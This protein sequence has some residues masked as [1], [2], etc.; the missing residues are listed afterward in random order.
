MEM[1]PLLA[2]FGLF[3][4]GMKQLEEAIGALAGVSFRRFVRDH[5]NTPCAASWWAVASPPCRR[6][7]SR[8]RCWCSPASAR[9]S[10]RWRARSA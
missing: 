10:C 5:A 3:M 9:T 1:L 6:A 2:G 8:S 7:V 4:L